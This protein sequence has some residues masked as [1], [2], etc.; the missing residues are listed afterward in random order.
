[1]FWTWARNLMVKK[2]KSPD[3]DPNHHSIL[4]MDGTCVACSCGTILRLQDASMLAL[5]LRYRTDKLL[6]LW[7][8]H[9]EHG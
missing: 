7:L 5:S 9:E 1:M 6:D 4:R 3:Y 2:S 8:L